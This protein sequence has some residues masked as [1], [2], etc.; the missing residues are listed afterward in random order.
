MKTSPAIRAGTPCVITDMLLQ[1]VEPTKDLIAS[2]KSDD[3]GD[4]VS[5]IHQ[6]ILKLFPTR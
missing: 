2:N 3:E 6:N 4:Y 5:L 1:P